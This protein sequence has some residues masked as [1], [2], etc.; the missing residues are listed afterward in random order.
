LKI[1]DTFVQHKLTKMKKSIF[2]SLLLLMLSALSFA[3]DRH[4]VT[5]TVRDSSGKP[6]PGAGVLIEGSTVGTV[7][8]IDGKYS[9]EVSSE[10]TLEV[11]FLGFKT[12]FGKPGKGA[13]LDFV[14][15][16]DSN[17]L[18]DVVVVGYGTQARKTLTTSVS[19]VDGESLVNA[20]VNSVG[21]ALKGRVAGLHVATSNA[22]SGETP[23]FLIR[24]GS[25]ITMNND[26]IF[27]I[28]G[29]LMDDLG[30][31]N[32]N[33]IESL[34]ILKDAASAGIYGAR[35]SNGVILVT[36]RKGNAYKGP[37][38]VFDVQ[39]GM[40]SPSSRWP[41]MNARDY[42]NYI[43]PA[44]ASAM[45]NDTTHPAASL[46]NG[47]NAYGTGNTGNK[48][49]FSTKYLDYNQPVPEGYEWMYDPIN[50]NNVIIFQDNDWQ[51]QWFSNAFWQ[52]EYVGVNGGNKRM[53]YAASV[54]YT[55][56]EGV[57]AVSGYNVFTMHGNTSFKINHA[58]E[59]GATFYM[60][61]QNKRVPIDNYYQV[62]G[63]GLIAAPTAMEKNPD[64][65][66]NQ[67]VAT[68]NKAHSPAWWEAFYDR[69][70]I[71]NRSTGSFYLKW[72]IF[73]DLQAYAQYTHF[74]ETYS[75]SYRAI[76]EVDGTVNSYHSNRPRTETRTETFRQTFS[77]HLTYNKTFLGGHNLSAMAGYEWM[78]QNY[79]Y[80]Q[81]KSSGAVTDD[82]TVLDA[83]VN[84]E[85]SSKEQS[86]A[87]ISYFGRLAYDYKNRYVASMTF[88]ADGSS[89]FA[90]GNRW[91]FFPA[92][93]LAWIVSEEPFFKPVTDKMNTLKLRASYGLTGNNSIGLFDTYGSYST[94]SYGPMSTIQPGAMQNSGMQWETTKQL[95]FG[96]DMGFFHDRIRLIV[97]YYNKVTENMLFSISLP[98]TSPY[99]SVKANVG[100]AKFYGCEVELH[101]VN[102]E[103]KD[104]SWT[105][106][107]TYSFSGNEVLSLPDE[108]MY[109][110]VD[111]DGNFTGKKVWR[112]GGYTMSETGYRYGGIAVGEPLGRIYGYKVDRIIQTL[113]EADNALYDNESF[114]YRVSD[115]K[116]IKGRK[117]VGDYEWCNMPGSAR[118]GGN[119]IINS[120]D[121][122]LLGNVTPHSTGGI[123]NTFR[124]KKLSLNVYMDF[125]LGHSIVNGMKTQLLKNTMGDC[126]SMLGYLVYDC[127]DHEG[128]TD[129]KYA[130]YTPNDSDWGNRN[131]RGISSFMVERAD[132]L[133]LRDVTLSYDLPETWFSKYGVK[134][135]TV[136]VS[137]NTLYYLTGVTGAVSTET[138]ISSSAGASM[139]T[140]VSTSN[141]DGDTRANMMP[142]PRKVLFN[143]KVFF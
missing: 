38:V 2:S 19:K 43:R 129:A 105:S 11:S 34:E 40:Q 104:F 114:G 136:G 47:P 69:S 55:D 89:K 122:F 49:L 119:E 63:R 7:T 67:L 81:G 12:V 137:G 127:W 126:N 73:K 36:T 48:A 85:A 28:D 10:E 142:N 25:S 109:D 121:M 131:W 53:K 132:Y 33:D 35:A 138:G 44:I 1:L 112:I 41:I 52:K 82:V 31:L 134:K 140:A 77:S 118:D 57:V 21:D 100:S 98:D 59:A 96:L 54:S 106:D 16:E 80:L 66:W 115:G 130:R 87:L 78:K 24:G 37:Q 79:I 72:D 92:A 4:V 62:I 29:A 9:L 74:D 6:L 23:R 26:P 14:L 103:T 65:E 123:G 125:A 30:G 83:G 39:M 95:D 3:Q 58:L 91:G 68:N 97:D 51:S 50:P 139:Y 116:R 56:D 111:I 32:P 64:G 5:G 141:S 13:V 60:S 93:S 107:F 128:D 15:K 75:G 88:R 143:V 120:E 18:Q 46:L 101:T 76:G 108:Y 135:V 117:D 20:P 110:E 124:Y 22:L 8:D 102:F 133:C 27:I 70:N 84:F 99:S 71:R 45:A 61:R 86:Q 90:E 113:E 42:L 17:L 94:S